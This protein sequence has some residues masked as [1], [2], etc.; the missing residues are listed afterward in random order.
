MQ[1]TY[2]DLGSK[3]IVTQTFTIVPNWRQDYVVMVRPHSSL[4]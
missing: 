1:R 2:D 3:H 4:D